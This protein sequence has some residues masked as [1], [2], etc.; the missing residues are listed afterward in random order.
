MPRVSTRRCRRRFP[1]VR[2]KNSAVLPYTLPLRAGWRGGWRERRG[3]LLRLETDDGLTG[4]GDCAPLAGEEHALSAW[5]PHL[6]GLSLED[7]LDGEVGA[8]LAPAALC[9]VDTALSDLAARYRELPL[10]RWLDPGANLS[11]WCNAALGTLDDAAAGRVQEAAEAGFT[12]FKFKVGLTGVE[13]ELTRLRRLAAALPPGSGLRLD[14][15]RA[16]SVADA[17]RFL[18]GAA[19]LPV[20]MLEEPLRCPDLTL[21]GQLQRQTPI[22]L[23]LDESLAELDMDAV[24]EANAVRRLVLKPMLLGGPRRAMRWAAAAR[25]RGTGCV[26]TTALESAAGVLAAAH[27]AAALGNGLHHGLATSGWLR[28]DTG[29]APPVR[30][31]RLWLDETPGLGFTPV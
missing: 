11:P 10:A 20:E 27:L 16:W 4:W 12:L 2:I 24:M 31:G 13:D 5:H 22:P 17:R 28:R 14:A 15:N 29:Q 30:A 6:R 26:A 18:D 1:P 25:A 9:A 19:G 8:G 7:A 3:M 21:L 23:A